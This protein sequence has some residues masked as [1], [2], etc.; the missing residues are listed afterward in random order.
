MSIKIDYNGNVSESRDVHDNWNGEIGFI[1][2]YNEPMGYVRFIPTN[3]GFYGS[4]DIEE[5]EAILLAMRSK[6][7]SRGGVK[8]GMKDWEIIEGEGK[9]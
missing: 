3:A 4:L 1:Q 9:L 7:A 8:A 2:N 5:M 6:V